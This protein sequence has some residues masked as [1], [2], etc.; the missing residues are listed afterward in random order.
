M[1]LSVVWFCCLEIDSADAI[2]VE[3][4]GVVEVLL[5]AALQGGDFAIADFKA[6][7]V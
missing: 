5:L 6:L 3:A 2:H 4:L 7:G 1:P